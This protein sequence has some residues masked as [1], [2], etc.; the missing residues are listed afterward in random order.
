MEAKLFTSNRPNPALKRDVPQAAR[1]LAQRWATPKPNQ[2]RMCGQQTKLIQRR[3]AQPEKVSQ[4]GAQP[5][6]S[7]PSFTTA[8]AWLTTRA[9]GTTHHGIVLLPQEHSAAKPVAHKAHSAIASPSA[10]TVAMLVFPLCAASP[11]RR[12]SGTP[13]KRGAP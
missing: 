4:P 2:K 12:S 13:Q 3:F 10:N 1:P 6:T 9:S 8:A 11:T 7:S 5:E